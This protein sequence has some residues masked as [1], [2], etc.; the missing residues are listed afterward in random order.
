MS[1]FC[2]AKT[3]VNLNYTTGIQPLKLAIKKADIQTI[4][5]SKK[6]IKKLQGKANLFF[7]HLRINSVAAKNLLAFKFMPVES[8]T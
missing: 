8:A 2:L 7:S 1:L 3:V 4:I 5:T 6:F